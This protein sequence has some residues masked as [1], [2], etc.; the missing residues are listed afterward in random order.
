VFFVSVACKGFSLAVSLLF[1]T[2]GE[3][4]ISVAAKGLKATMGDVNRNGKM[5]YTLRCGKNSAEMIEGEGDRCWPSRR[6]MPNRLK[7]NGLNQ[8]Q[9]KKIG[10]G[11][12]SLVA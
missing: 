1:A 10:A 3:R 4:P 12:R 11:K 9:G 2:F 8:R 6:G 5:G 7:R